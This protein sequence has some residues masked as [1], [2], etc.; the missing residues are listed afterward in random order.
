[1]DQRDLNELDALVEAAIQFGLESDKNIQFAIKS[2]EMLRM[3]KRQQEEDEMLFQQAQEAQRAGEEKNARLEKEL[4]ELEMQVGA[5][6]D[7]IEDDDEEEFEQEQIRNQIASFST[8]TTATTTTSSSS[9]G[10]LFS[11]S[12]SAASTASS[13]FPSLFRAKQR[14]SVMNPQK[15]NRRGTMVFT[16][17]EEND[18][19][20]PQ[21]VPI[22]G[23]ME[24]FIPC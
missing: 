21:D 10:S 13:S 19:E 12:S 16:D 3:E 9:A 1:L 17:I 18:D 22:V 5:D 15:Q 14:M 7:E 11:S 24:V 4:M 2:L 20:V 8:T 23:T 6:K